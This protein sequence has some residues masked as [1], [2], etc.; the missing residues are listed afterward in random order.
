VKKI[1]THN[2]KPTDITTID[3]A[4]HLKREFGKIETWYHDAIFKNGY[5]LVNLINVLHIGRFG[6]I[7]TGL[8]IYKDNKPI[9][10][11]RNRYSLSSF[12]GNEEILHIKIKDKDILKT[13]INDKNE[14]ITKLTRKE[15]NLKI[16]LDFIKKSKGFKGTTYLGN[17]L[18][19]PKMNVQGLINIGNELINVDGIGYHD[20]NIYPIYTPFKTRGYNFGKLNINSNHLT[21]ARVIKNKN[22]EQLLAVI[23]K[24]QEFINI[25][26]KSIKYKILEE[27]K[28]KRK[29][30]P[31][32]FSINIDHEKIKLK[33]V[34][35]PINYH[36]IGVLITHYWRFHVRYKGEI[37]IDKM[38]K[39]ID[40]VEI[41]E[42]LKFF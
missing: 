20:H 11:I 42:Y 27:I 10:I 21:W 28:D 22:K 17:W 23:S 37:I 19:I 9:K 41:I 16:N 39:N 6:I 34:A 35:E 8:F 15:K 32:K 1:K 33:L 26:K 2:F 7:L 3:D 29:K 13:H 5:S 14:W 30:I 24:N 36:Y 31:T 40:T 12:K 38:K 18:A 25:P 4:C